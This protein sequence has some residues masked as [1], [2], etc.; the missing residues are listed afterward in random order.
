[1]KRFAGVLLACDF[2]NTIA[3]TGKCFAAGLPFPGV[4]QENVEAIRRFMAQGGLFSVVTGR[5]YPAFLHLREQVPTNAPTALF[6]GAGIYDFAKGEYLW[7][8]RLPQGA[9]THYHEVLDTFPT[10]GME[11]FSWDERVFAVRPNA[12]VI[13]HQTLT[14]APWTEVAALE[15]TGIEAAKLLFEDEY[16]VLLEVQRFLRSRPWIG[17]YDTIFSSPNLLEL[18]ARGARKADAVQELARLHGIA[19]EHIYCAGDEENDLSML[20]L[21]AEGFVPA[22]CNPKLLGRGFTT[23]GPCTEHAVADIVA[24]L[25]RKYPL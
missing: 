6:N 18:T 1:M 9:F 11:A 10:V 17:E 21:A 3:P 24:A 22:D 25:E 15:D 20:E 4:P 23:V 2:D 5:A 7:Q 8:V 12:F 19:P 14:R 16:E 13:R